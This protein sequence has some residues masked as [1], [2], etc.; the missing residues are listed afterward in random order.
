MNHPTPILP[1]NVPLTLFECAVHA[2]FP[3]PAADYAQR[4]IDLNQHLL[5]NENSSFLFRVRG[6]SMKDIGIY[7]GDTLIVDRS[8]SPLH[9]QI[10]LAVIDGE[11]TVKRLFK[12]GKDIRLI[13]EN[14]DYPTIELKEGQELTIWGVVT[15]CL[16]RLLN[17]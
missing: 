11:F 13:P 10:V 8:V 1:G 2:G 6:D 4:R 9:N 5:L 15:F 14:S 17:V 3:S 12:R 16:H 7:E